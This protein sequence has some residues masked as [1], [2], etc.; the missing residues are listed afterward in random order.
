MCEEFKNP[1]RVR[2]G[3]PEASR[4][5]ESWFSILQN[6][7][8]SAYC[9]TKHVYI[10]IHVLNIKKKTKKVNVATTPKDQWA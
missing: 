10:H 8:N 2:G 3:S 1:F 7:K 6:K 4:S 5:E 9:F